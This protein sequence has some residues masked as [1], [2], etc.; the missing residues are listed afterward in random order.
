MQLFL[1][2]NLEKSRSFIYIIE[3]ATDI[4]PRR[5]S[6]L[7]SRSSKFDG[8]DALQAVAGRQRG[9]AAPFPRNCASA[10]HS[11]CKLCALLGRV[12]G[13]TFTDQTFLLPALPA[14]GM[15]G[16]AWGLSPGA[17]HAPRVDAGGRDHAGMLL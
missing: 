13:E 3:I 1:G 7:W 10:Q 8:E 14:A 16:T 4:L 9:Q 12:M 6:T 2:I 15:L 5:N 17:L 11:P